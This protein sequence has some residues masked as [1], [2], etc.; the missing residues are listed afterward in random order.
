MRT[1]GIR[2]A[3]VLCRTIVPLLMLTF[4]ASSSAQQSWYLQTSDGK[5]HEFSSKAAWEQSAKKNGPLET[6]VLNI[7]RAEITVE[8]DVQGESGDWRSVDNYVA[9]RDGTVRSLK[10]VFVSV[11]Q[12]IKVVSLYKKD[13]ATGTIKR[14]SMV[15][16]SLSTG[17]KTSDPPEVPQVSIVKNIYELDGLKKK[18]AGGGGWPGFEVSFAVAMRIARNTAVQQF[19]E[20]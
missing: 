19:P 11:E 16:T 2:K 3:A 17:A 6:L 20:T 14:A 18:A 8:Y 10:R 15:E 13:V 9:E 12:D 4:C 1:V 5:W 7:G